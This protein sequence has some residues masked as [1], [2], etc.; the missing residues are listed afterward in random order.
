MSLIIC[1]GCKKEVSNQSSICIHC[2]YPLKKI[3]VFPVG[4][5]IGYDCPK[6]GDKNMMCKVLNSNIQNTEACCT[7]CGDSLIIDFDKVILTQAEYDDIYDDIYDNDVDIAIE[8]IINI[9]GC[10]HSVAKQYV[11]NE[12]ENIK[13]IEQ[14]GD[15][16]HTDNRR[17][18]IAKQK[19]ALEKEKRAQDFQY[20]NNAECPYCHS[21][22]TRKISSLSKAGNIA[23][24]GIF[25]LGKT[26][27]QWHCNNCKS[28]F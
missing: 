5:I 7:N 8:K 6:C 13:K 16:K 19:E 3:R 4:T 1:P 17:E 10:N 12:I 18:K 14:L 27:K 11:I 15:F 2:G 26:S 28:D 22:N 24:F 23:L 21:K 25:S 20:R 9:T